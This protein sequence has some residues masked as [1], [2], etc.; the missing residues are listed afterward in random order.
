MEGNEP[1]VRPFGF[2]MEYE[3]KLYF[4]TNNK[5]SVY[6]QLMANPN[7]EISTANQK[8]EWIR[9]KG[10]AVFDNNPA[11]KAKALE[12]SPFLTKMYSVDSPIFEVFYLKDGEAAFCAMNGQPPKIV[13]I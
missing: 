12:V 6:K 1:K 3:G 8:G 10:K 11:A 13:K 2:A 4:C 9:I 7:C 5:K